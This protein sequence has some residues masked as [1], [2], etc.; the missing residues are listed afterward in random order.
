MF[1]QCIAER[2][3]AVRSYRRRQNG[4]LINGITGTEEASA[5]V[6]D[7]EECDVKVLRGGAN[8]D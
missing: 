2:E 6:H 7:A 1:L 8:T 4:K 5:Q 3:A